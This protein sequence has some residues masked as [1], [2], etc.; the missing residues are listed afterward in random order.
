VIVYP[1]GGPRG[2]YGY[3]WDIFPQY[4]LALGY[5][6][7]APNYRGSTGFGYEFEH[8]NDFNWGIGDTQ[9]VLYA[10]R[11]LHTQPGIDPKRLAIY[12]GSYGGYMTI[13]CLARDPD[14]LFSCGVDMYGDADTITSWAT[15][16]RRL[17]LYSEMQLGDPVHNRQVYIDGSP[18]YQIAN[19]Q[20]PLLMLHGNSD[21][22]VPNLAS[23]EIVDALLRADKTFEYKTY[24][25]EGHGFLHRDVVLDVYQR[26]ER[27]LDWYLFPAGQWK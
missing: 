14:Y 26:V 20:K 12:G 13:S 1:H 4:L 19:I 15:S 25:D 16:N 17:S 18:I 27:F 10:A 24:P 6:I 5:T 23:E 9:D 3:D 21:S 7:L 8:A 11:F 22:V 2:Q